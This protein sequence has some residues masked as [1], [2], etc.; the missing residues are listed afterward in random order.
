MLLAA[1]LL[2]TG[3][4]GSSNSIVSSGNLTPDDIFSGGKPEVDGYEVP[5]AMVDITSQKLVSNIR[6]GWN[7]GYSLE[8]CIS[9]LDGNT[10][11]DATPPTGKVPDETLWGNPPASEQLF[12]A[13]VDSG[14]NAVRIPI[15]WRGHVDREFNINEDWLNRV[16]QVV[17]YAY[18]CGMYVIITVYHDGAFDDDYGAWIRNAAK[19]PDITIEHYKYLWEQIADKFHAYNERLLYESMN[20]VEFY[21]YPE[22][23]AYDLFNRL[24]QEFVNTIRSS[25]GNNLRR[26]L[27]IAGY[28]ADINSTCS[29]RFVMPDDP[30]NKCILSV[31][32]YTPI[33]FCR[34]SIR[35]YWGIPSEQRWMEQQI[36]T[37]KTQFVDKGIPVMITE[38][39]AKG[40]DAA[41]RVFFCEKLVKLCRD[42]NIAAF[43][44]DDGSELDRTT[45][46]WRTPELIEALKRA[47][48][49]EDYT[50][51]KLYEEPVQD[52]DDF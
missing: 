7:L 46:E 28:N 3:C 32:Y 39:G 5:S 22:A 27:V 2:L 24:N 10:L 30:A 45:F 17:D 29:S 33:T 38:Y 15:T 19:E 12:N 37:L 40:S 49:G 25:N 34:E 36:D 52:A 9:D 35:N 44:W 51:K 4:S 14:I 21:G 41:S 16:K 31:H 43:L 6:I 20:E 48:C 23:E 18:N 1:V 50:P 13:L 8:A 47:S 11:P 42:S 26:H